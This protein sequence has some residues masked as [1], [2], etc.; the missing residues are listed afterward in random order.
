MTAC[1][2]AAK[3]SNDDKS[4]Y[5][6]IV[7]S[8]AS[9]IIKLQNV[10]VSAYICVF[11]TLQNLYHTVR[12]IYGDSKSG[13][14]GTLW[15]VTYS[16]VGHGN[17]AGPE[18]WSVVSTPVFKVMKDEG[19]GFMYKR[20]IERKQLHFLGY[21]FVDDTAIIQS[22]QPGEPFQV[23][24]TRLQATMDTREG[25]L[26]DTGGVLEPEKSFWYLIRVCWKN[27]QW[28]YVSNED[29]PTSISVSNHAGDRVELERL[30]VAEARNTLGVNTAPTRDTTAH[31]EHMMEASHKWAALIKQRPG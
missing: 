24:A 27:G 16:D 14:R 4:C 17:G 11:T 22:G 23:L 29:T 28:A 26:W 21:I 13:N 5:D 2:D 31:F 15:A 20:S 1:M 9:I 6:R 12:T 25:G 8:I 7:H 3:C 19:F 30:E 10:P 18:I